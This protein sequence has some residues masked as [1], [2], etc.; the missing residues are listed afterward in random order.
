ML[1]RVCLTTSKS[2][3]CFFIRDEKLLVDVLHCGDPVSSS[4]IDSS[5]SSS[6]DVNFENLEADKFSGPSQSAM[7][8]QTILSPHVRQNLF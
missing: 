2:G 6:S 5:S 3:E 1:V 8:H 4:K 7:S